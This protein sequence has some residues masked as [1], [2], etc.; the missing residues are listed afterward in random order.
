MIT[1]R[2]RQVVADALQLPAES[3]TDDLAFNGVPSWDSIN[4]ISLM[5]SLEETF[6]IS[7]PDDDVVELTSVRAIDLYIAQRGG[8]SEDRGA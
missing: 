6:G 4:H 1:D 7:I 8:L 2:V 3:I 5:L